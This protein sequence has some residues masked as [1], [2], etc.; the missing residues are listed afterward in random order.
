ME[1]YNKYKPFIYS[2]LIAGLVF[3]LIMLGFDYYNDEPFS[4]FKFLMHFVFFGIFNSYLAY[5]KH[6]KDN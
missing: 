3:A 2:G 1:I 4:L 5:R 6:K